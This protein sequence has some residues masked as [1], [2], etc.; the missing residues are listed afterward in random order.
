MLKG[1][2]A[3]G[4]GDGERATRTTLARHHGDD[5]GAEFGHLADG[6]GD[7]LGDAVLFGFRTRVRTRGVDQG[8]E[9]Q[10]QALGKLKGAHRL[11]IPLWVRHAES[12]A[13]VA[14]GVGPLLGPHHHNASPIDARNARNDRAVITGAPIAAQL[15]KLSAK[16]LKQFSSAW[17]IHFAGALHVAPRLGLIKV[18]PKLWRKVSVALVLKDLVG[19]IRHLRSGISN[20]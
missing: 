6:G 15:H 2:D 3:V 19:A 4:G 11:A 10:V 8:E 9:R 13:N 12:A 1:E 14:L 7:R 5:W 16:R 20:R 17:S 18:R